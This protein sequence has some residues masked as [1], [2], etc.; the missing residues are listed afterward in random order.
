MATQDIAN[1]YWN[2]A[3]ARPH[4][5]HGLGEPPR[6]QTPQMT[7]LARAQ[8]RSL[9][10]LWVI[11][12]VFFGAG[13]GLQLFALEGVSLAAR[14]QGG[15]LPALFFGLAIASGRRATRRRGE[16]LRAMVES[17][18]RQAEVTRMYSITKRRGRFST[19][20]EYHVVFRVEGRAVELVTLNAGVSLLQAGL[21]EQVLWIPEV[22]H[23]VVPTFLLS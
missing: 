23:V 12:L 19:Y 13:F 7:A 9:T 14:L 11:L 20:E 5:A 4:D 15:L 3:G 17:P 18:L 10:A 8:A 1:A 21:T 2:T 16:W 22:P 6:A